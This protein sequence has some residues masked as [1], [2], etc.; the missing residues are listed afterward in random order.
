MNTFMIR[1]S[2]SKKQASN[3]PS[4]FYVLHIIHSFAK[5]CK[6]KNKDVRRF[7][8]H[9]I[10]LLQNCHDLQD[11]R[12]IVRRMTTLFSTK[13]ESRKTQAAEQWLRTRMEEQIFDEKRSGQSRQ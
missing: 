9:N 8:L 1:V 3:T 13:H 2:Q 10:A 6:I 4:C 5:L 7:F 12:R 11:A